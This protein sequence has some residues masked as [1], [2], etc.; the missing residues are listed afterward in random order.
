MKLKNFLYLYLFLCVGILSGCIDNDENEQPINPPASYACYIVNQGNFTEQ[1]GEISIYD[2]QTGNIQNDVY[3]AAN[4]RKLGSMVESVTVHGDLL[5]VMCNTVDKI[6]FLN[7]K[8]MQEVCEPITSLSTPRYA[9]I[10]GDKMYVSCWAVQ[11]YSTWSVIKEQE[12]AV[13]DLN[14]KSVI[15]H[16]KTTGTMPEGMNITGNNLFVASGAG[17]DVY[18]TN[19][20]T[21]IK[22]ITST[23]TGDA[24]K[25]EVDKNR[26][27]W[28]SIG[29]FD[30]N[31]CGFMCINTQD[32]TANAEFA[33]PRLGMEGEIATSP[34]ND[35]IYFLPSLDYNDYSASMGI[36]ELNVDSKTVSD[37]PVIKGVGFYGLGV[38][39]LT[40]NIYTANINAFQTNSTML[41]YNPA[42]NLLDSKTV[43]VNACRWVFD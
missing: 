32:L 19:T 43:G 40:G 34:K 12:I 20:D 9:A 3:R 33:E 21:Q 8:T 37:N 31:Q 7:S 1:N 18:D 25:M 14:T 16:L 39:S 35:K 5:V 38:D 28:V 11:D 4:G 6:V 36:Y 15:K 2:P 22:R 26:M 24:Q 13:I 23:L 10:K 41:I 30:S 42:G 29:S 17:V 27:L